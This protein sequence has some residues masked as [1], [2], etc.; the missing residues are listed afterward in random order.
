[1]GVSNAGRLAACERPMFP[2]P[3][4]RAILESHLEVLILW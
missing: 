2:L 4:G 3:L 1:M